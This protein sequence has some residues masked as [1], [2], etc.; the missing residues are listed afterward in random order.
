MPKLRESADELFRIAD[1]QSGFFTTQQAVEA[2]FDPTNVTYHVRA[3]NWI[4][5]HRGIYRLSNYPESP[6]ADLVLWSLWSRNREQVPQGVYSHQTALSIHGVTELL[7]SKLHM[8]VP[9]DFRR[10]GKLPPILVLHRARLSSADIQ[11]MRGFAVTRPLRA[12][13]DLLAERSVSADI[14]RQAVENSLRRGLLTTKE[15]QSQDLE[16][17]NEVLRTIS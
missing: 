17:L 12:I 4:R 7:P 16:G 8:T 9:P 5:E 14:L 3:G 10:S 6:Q 13:R 15:I 11:P 1:S 2:G